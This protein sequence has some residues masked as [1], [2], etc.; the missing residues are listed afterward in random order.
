MHR[1]ATH[2]LDAILAPDYLAGLT[3]LSIDEIRRR[4][5][6]CQEVEVSLS[7]SRRIVQGRLDIVLAE[8]RHRN[9]GSATD[10]HSLVDELPEI[11][12]EKVHASGNGRLSTFLAPGEP[13]LDPALLARVDAVADNRRLSDLPGI[14]SA[15]V[16]GMVDELRS[17]EVDI[18][19][20]RRAL[21]ERIDALQEELVQR[22]KEQYKSGEAN[23]DS[24]LS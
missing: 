5:S 10:L 22:Y 15:E 8:M 17:L 20:Q 24:W 9:D 19:T 3:E 16:D 13:E 6:E 12:S 23:V 11:L 4:R 18:S 7:Y 14:S 1:V 2:R 21:H